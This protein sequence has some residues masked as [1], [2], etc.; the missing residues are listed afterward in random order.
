MAGEKR[1]TFEHRVEAVAQKD[2]DEL[3]R[4]FEHVLVEVEHALRG[5][6]HS[7]S[8]HVEGGIHHV[9]AP[10]ADK[11]TPPQEPATATDATVTPEAPKE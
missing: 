8:V 11:P 5:G 3:K 6:A 1:V 10:A 7:V 4:A 2:L 9:D